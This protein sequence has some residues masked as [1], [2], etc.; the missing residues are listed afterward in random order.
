MSELMW[1]HTQCLVELNMLSRIRQVIFTTDHV[2]DL[3]FD[4]VDNVHEMKNP[5]AIRAANG[6][7]RFHTA[8]EFDASTHL[9]INHHRTSRR[10]KPECSSILVDIALVLE[11]LEVLFIDCV[12]FA[13][14]IGSEPATLSGPFVPL[15]TKPL[16]AVINYLHRLVMFATL[17]GILNAKHKGTA[18]VPSEKPI[19]KSSACSSHVQKTGW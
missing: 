16:Q 19:K 18:M 2:R 4:I 3:H 5:R 6:H 9:I 12:A 11:S 17:V 7:I 13:L 15:Q 1:L 10:S 8:V 14:E